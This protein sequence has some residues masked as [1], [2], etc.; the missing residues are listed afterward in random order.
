[1]AEASADTAAPHRSATSREAAHRLSQAG[2]ARR[3]QLLLGLA[4]ALL[5]L[6]ACDA[7]SGPGSG[8][9]GAGGA[10]AAPAAVELIPTSPGAIASCVAE[11]GATYCTSADALAAGEACV[12]RL[13]SDEQ[14]GCDPARGCFVPYTPIRPGPCVSGPTYPSLAACATPVLDNCAFYRSCLEEA[15]PCGADG[16]ALAFGEQ[17]C[18]RFIDRRDAFTPAGQKWLEGVRTCLQRALAPLVSSPS[19]SCDALADEAYASHTAC[20]TDP[21]NSF[22]ALPAADV[23]TLAGIL[24]PYLGDPKVKAQV[25]AVNAACAAADAGAPDAG[26]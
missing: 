23:I 2:T 14:A 4:A 20:Y 12:A 22:C 16:Y 15:H 18:Y 24:F 10:P 13:T 11:L 26:P 17:L 8:T 21:D 19:S 7:P 3:A 1:M 5:A 25:Q 6:P 9:G